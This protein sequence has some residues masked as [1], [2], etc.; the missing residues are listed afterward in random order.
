MLTGDPPYIGSTAQAVL[1]KIIQG[2]PVSATEIRGSVPANVD[3]AIRKSL[4]KLPADRFTGAQDFARALGDPGF[5]HGEAVAT[6]PAGSAARGWLWGVAGVALGIAAGIYFGGPDPSAEGLGPVRF[7]ISVAETG[8][9][10]STRNYAAVA[11]S[12]DGSTIGYAAQTSYGGG[13]SSNHCPVATSEASGRGS[14]PTDRSSTPPGNAWPTLWTGPDW[15]L[16][17]PTAPVG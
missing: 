12:P 7:P 6:A 2:A 8:E 3:A 13:S 14:G 17:V 5:R 4:E 1:G 15:R 10:W 16:W 9:L 11:I